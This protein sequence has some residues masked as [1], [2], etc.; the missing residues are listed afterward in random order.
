[1]NQYV[2]TILK[3][4]SKSQALCFIEG[5]RGSES[6]YFHN[7]AKNISEVMKN[8]Q[9]SMKRMEKVKRSSQ[10][11]TTFVVMLTSML[12]RLTSPAESILDIPA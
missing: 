2:E 4:M 11:Y 3:F 6:K 8:P 1:M 5:L 9:P 12:P 10:S 7:V